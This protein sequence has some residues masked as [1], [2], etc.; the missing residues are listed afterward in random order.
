MM[1][2][3]LCPL[4]TKMVVRVYRRMVGVEICDLSIDCSNTKID[5]RCRWAVSNIKKKYFLLTHVACLFS[6]LH[7]QHLTQM[8]YAGQHLTDNLLVQF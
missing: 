5:K 8:F 4:T 6:M 3:H 7:W 1:S 2:S